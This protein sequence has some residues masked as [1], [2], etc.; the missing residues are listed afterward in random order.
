MGEMSVID[1]ALPLYQVVLQ[2]ST[3]STCSRLP[4]ISAGAP[5]ERG[6]RKKVHPSILLCL[7][8]PFLSFYFCISSLIEAIVGLM[9]ICSN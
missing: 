2:Y 4:S 3:M 5:G 6:S 9:A 1:V 7:F 8:L